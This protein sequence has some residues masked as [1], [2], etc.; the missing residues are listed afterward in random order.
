MLRKDRED[1]ACFASDAH[2]KHLWSEL[3]LS[4]DAVQRR[5]CAGEASEGM[6]LAGVH[7]D[8]ALEHGELVKPVR[9]P[10]D[11]IVAVSILTR[12]CRLYSGLLAS[13][14]ASSFAKFACVPWT[15]A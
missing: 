3:E 12:W 8:E 13:L 5:R 7:A 1:T 9:P 10:G 6:I 2:D 4:T 11:S 15:S 14:A